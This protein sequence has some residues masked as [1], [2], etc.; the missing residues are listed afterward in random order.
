[1]DN[2]GNSRM[3]SVNVLVWASWW[4]TVESC[5]HKRLTA[6]LWEFSH[7]AI[8]GV[9]AEWSKGNMQWAPALPL[10]SGQ[11]WVDRSD[12]Q[13]KLQDRWVFYFLLPNGRWKHLH[14]LPSIEVERHGYSNGNHTC[15]HTA[16]G[17]RY[18]MRS[19]V[20][21]HLSTQPQPLNLLRQR[22]AA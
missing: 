12:T 13:V 11:R 17:G 6:D 16:N 5:R 7:T 1:M 3:T 4:E 18:Q 14:S 22:P 9:Y 10:I 21:A 2:H 19:T 20:L 8:S 15:K